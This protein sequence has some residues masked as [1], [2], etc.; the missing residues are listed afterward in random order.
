LLLPV[1]VGYV[2]RSDIIEFRRQACDWVAAATGLRQPRQKLSPW[3]E[4][5]NGGD[6]ICLDKVLMRVIG[7]I[8][9]SFTATLQARNVPGV[10]VREA[11]NQ[12]RM[13]IG[14]RLSFR[15]LLLEHVQPRRLA[16]V[17]FR[18]DHKSIEA[19]YGLGIQLIVVNQ[20]G[21]WLEPVKDMAYSWR[22]ASALASVW[23]F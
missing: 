19:I 23:G 8:E 18:P 10:P 4:P 17:D 1:S 11:L 5:I 22:I 14:N 7:I 21:H 16:M 20:P 3:K 2:A 9:M 12:V 15:R 13:A 6:R